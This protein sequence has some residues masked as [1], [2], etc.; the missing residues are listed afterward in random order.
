MEGKLRKVAEKKGLDRFKEHWECTVS[1][2]PRIESFKKE[3]VV[4]G[5]TFSRKIY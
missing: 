2:K 4:P 1:P 3:E 5:I